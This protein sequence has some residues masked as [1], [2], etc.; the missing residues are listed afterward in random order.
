VGL[1][2]RRIQSSRRGHRGVLVLSK[3]AAEAVPGG[4]GCLDWCSLPVSLKPPYP[5]SPSP[6]RVRRRLFRTGARV[7]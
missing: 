6:F 3:I 1:T 2:Q 7:D 5:R 4:V